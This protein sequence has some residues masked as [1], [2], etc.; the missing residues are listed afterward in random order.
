VGGLCLLEHGAAGGHLQWGGRH[1]QRRRLRDP[2]LHPGPAGLHHGHGHGRGSAAGRGAHGVDLLP[3]L[4]LRRAVP[5]QGRRGHHRPHRC[6]GGAKGGGQRAPGPG[7]LRP[8]HQQNGRLADP[9]LRDGVRPAPGSALHRQRHA[10]RQPHHSR[11][12]GL[13]PVGRGLQQRPHGVCE[14]LRRARSAHRLQEP[15]DPDEVRGHLGRD[16]RHQPRPGGVD[17]TVAP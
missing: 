9:R 11:R 6:G 7:L 17:Q 1:L 12:H 2:D 13:P 8:C 3:H 16:G 10:V 4:L 14:D 5:A 15:G